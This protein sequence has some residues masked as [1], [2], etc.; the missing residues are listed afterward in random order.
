M[1]FDMKKKLKIV[2]LDRGTA[3]SIKLT[4]RFSKYG[5]YIEYDDTEKNEL[6]ERIKDADVLILNRIKLGKKEFEKAPLLKLILITATGFNHIDIG[7]AN[8]KGIIVANVTGYST[9]SVAQLTMTLMLNELTKVSRYSD[10]VKENGWNAITYSDVQNY[11]IDDTENKIVGIIGYGDIGKKVEEMVKN[12]GMKTMIAEIPGREYKED[13][14][15]N[16]Y[17][18]DKVL[19]TCDILSIHAPLTDLTRN[20][21][22]LDKIK[23]MKKSSIILNLGRGPIINEEDLYEALKNNII[24]SAAID[25]MSKEPPEENSKMFELENL[26]ITPHIAWKSQKSLERLFEVIENNMNLFLEGKLEG[27]KSL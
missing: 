3:G 7:A 4:E 23:K 2:C 20:L 18:L 11:P 13:N 9:N 15:E 12:F 25:V 10:K 16:R 17:K 5:E 1:V 26:T 24:R 21:I 22:T 6:E 27:L 19:E 14:T 8:E